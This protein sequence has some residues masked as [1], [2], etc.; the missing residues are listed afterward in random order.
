VR[1]PVEQFGQRADAPGEDPHRVAGGQVD[2]AH[3]RRRRRVVPVTLEHTV[4]AAVQQVAEEEA[5]AKDGNSV[6]WS[7]LRGSTVT[8][9]G[10]TGYSI[11]ARGAAW[12][13]YCAEGCIESQ[14]LSEVTRL[15][16]SRAF[17]V[18]SPSIA[19]KTTTV[20]RVER[21]LGEAHAGTYAEIENDSTYRS[22]VAATDA[23]SAVGADLIVAVGGGSVIVAAR[24]VDIF[25]C[26][27]GDPFEIMTQYPAGGRAYSPRLNAPKLPIINV[28]TTPTAAMNRAGS[29]LKN[30]DLNHRMEYFDPKTRPASIIWDWEALAATPFRVLRSTATTTFIASWVAT[31]REESNPLLKADVRQAFISARDAFLRLTTDPDAIT[32]R[33]DLCAA[34]FLSNRAEDDSHGPLIYESSGEGFSTGDYAI[35]TAIHVRY[36]DVGQGEANGAL[37]A[38]SIRNSPTASL[39]FVKRGAAAL[40]CWREGMSAA[41]GQEAIAVTLEGLLRRIRMPTRVSELGFPRED[42]QAI[43][44]ETVINFNANSGVRSDQARIDASIALLEAAW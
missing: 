35:S 5:V 36:P 43:A 39:E 28:V 8:E 27:D 6:R 25:I 12:R 22:V 40:G 38:A 26:E 18:T 7:D 41:A 17:I 13:L 44:R 9:A 19:M 30:P 15:G 31:L 11:V 23:A 20:G 42:I 34:A 24:A 21:A 3:A 32:P 1:H 10:M 16:A 14:L 37:L 29:G 2:D 4:K 33:L